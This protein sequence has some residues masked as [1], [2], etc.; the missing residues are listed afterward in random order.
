[1]GLGPKR[2]ALATLHDQKKKGCTLLRLTVMEGNPGSAAAL[3]SEQHAGV[4]LA[5]TKND[6]S[7]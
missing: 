5:N 3:T 4:L 2:S 1:M 6:N 7:L